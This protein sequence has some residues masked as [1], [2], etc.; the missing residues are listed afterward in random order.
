[1]CRSI[2]QFDF[3]TRSSCN[4][5]DVSG[6]RTVA[7][8]RA[9]GYRS[10]PSKLCNYESLSALNNN[11]RVIRLVSFGSYY[12]DFL[13]YFQVFKVG[14]THSF[15][16]LMKFVK[17][18]GLRSIIRCIYVSTNLSVALRA[19]RDH[20]SRYRRRKIIPEKWCSHKCDLSGDKVKSLCLFIHKILP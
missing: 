8:A 9:P 20:R 19:L 6:T 16:N 14:T 13:R 3:H 11:T 18:R 10:P 1:M 17:D 2:S 4:K 5:N 12:L 15:E 7:R